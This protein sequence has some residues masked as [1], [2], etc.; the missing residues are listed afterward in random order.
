MTLHLPQAGGDQG[1]LGVTPPFDG[2]HALDH[3]PT[4]EDAAQRVRGIR[5]VDHHAATTEHGSSFTQGCGIRTQT[6][7]EENLQ[8]GTSAARSDSL[9][10]EH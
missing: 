9:P 8:M 2:H 5:G 3:S 4:A 7:N 1:E 10:A 6:V